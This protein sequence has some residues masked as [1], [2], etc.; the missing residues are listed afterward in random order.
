MLG[1]EK[2]ICW[3]KQLPQ[4]HIQATRNFNTIAAIIPIVT[5][6]KILLYA[7]HYSDFPFARA[8]YYLKQT[9]KIGTVSLSF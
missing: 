7:I 8:I 5:F 3:G 9:L 4:R 2:E 6:T 1:V